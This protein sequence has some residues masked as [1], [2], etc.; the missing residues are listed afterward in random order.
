V[1]KSHCKDSFIF[2]ITSKLKGVICIFYQPPRY[3]RTIVSR[4]SV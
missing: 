4:G 2:E 1:K 3:C